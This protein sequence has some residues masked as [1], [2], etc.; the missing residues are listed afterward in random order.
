MNKDGM[1]N[2]STSAEQVQ[3]KMVMIFQKRKQILQQLKKQL[4]SQ[5]TDHG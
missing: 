5:I 1:Q 2:I 3:D 4:T